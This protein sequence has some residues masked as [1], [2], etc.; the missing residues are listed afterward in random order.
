MLLLTV[1]TIPA[2]PANTSKND[3]NERSSVLFFASDGL[4]QD[5]IEKYA[6]RGVV[7]GFRDLLRKVV[8]ASGD[9][10]LTQAPPNTGA[11]WFTLAT[12]AWPAV[13]GSTNN[14]F[15]VNGAPFGNRTT[16]F[17]AGVLQAETIAQSAERGGLKVAQ[18]EWAGGRSGAIQG[19]TLDFRTFLSGRGVATNYISPDRPPKLRC[20]LRVAIRPSRRLRRASTLPAGRAPPATGWTNVPNSFSPAQEMR[21]RVLD[22]GVDKYG[23]DAYIYDSTNDNR[24]SYNRVL[25]SPRRSLGSTR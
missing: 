14:T 16:A 3:D 1:L 18:I 10:L 21:L 22:F 5:L 6:E 15:H 13:T 25:F 12:G 19:P 24:T 2:A 20:R 4:R 11:G 7:P 9:G 8:K 23:L 17:D